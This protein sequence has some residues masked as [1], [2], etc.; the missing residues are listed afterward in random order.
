MSD[1]TLFEPDNEHNRKLKSFVAP[2][3]WTN[4]E[5]A[6]MYNL[7]VIGAG[8]CGLIASAGASGLGAKVALIERHAMGGDCLNVGCVPSKGVIRAARAAAQAS[9]SAEFGVLSSEPEIDFTKAMN[10]MRELRAGISHVD[11][12]ERYQK[13]LGVDVFLGEASFS[14]ENT[15]KVDGKTLHFKKALIATGARAARIPVPGLWESGAH[16]NETIFSITE[17]PKRLAV[18]GG[19]PIGAELSQAFARFGSE[20]YVFDNSDQ[21]LNREDQDAAEIVQKALVNDGVQ[22]RCGTEIKKVTTEGDEK[23]IHYDDD[24]GQMQ[25]LRIDSILVAVGRAPNIEGLNLEKAGITY[26]KRGIEVDD[27]LRTA[28]KNIF[29]AGDV[30]MKFQFTHTADAAARM[31][32]QNA[33]FHGRKKLSDLVIPWCTYTEPEIAHVGMYQADAKDQGIETDTYVQELDDVD[34]A[35]LDGETEGFVKVLTK[36]GSSEILGA[37]IVAAHA[38]DMISEL[39]LAITHGIGLDKIA[40]TIHPYP[41][42]AEAIKKVADSYSRTKLTPF[43]SKLFKKWLA[44][45]RG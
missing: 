2:D 23:I 27:N 12:V 34:R 35:I 16:T 38:G 33:L 29:A 3:D 43:I 45:S 41:T 7:V 4:P 30:A 10:R 11:G 8:P 21:I 14:S 15:I 32:I 44:W 24:S 5:P 26:H 22:L 39:T 1:N 13:E 42:Q 40:S 28:N 18:I 25:E 17:L 31:V 9:R 6:E 19:G 20:V 37:T 36:K